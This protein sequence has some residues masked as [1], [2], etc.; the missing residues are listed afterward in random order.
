MQVL[1]TLGLHAQLCY[2]RV[3]RAGF[4]QRGCM[5]GLQKSGVVNSGVLHKGYKCMGCARVVDTGFAHATTG[6]DTQPI[7]LQ[8]LH[9]QCCVQGL[10]AHRGCV[11][12]F[13]CRGC[14]QGLCVQGLHARVAHR[15]CMHR[16]A[17][18]GLH[19]HRG[20]T[21]K[22]HLTMYRGCTCKGGGDTQP[23]R[24]QG[25]MQGVVRKGCACR[26]CVQGLCMC[27]G[28]MQGLHMQGLHRGCVQG[29]CTRVTCMHKGCACKGCVHRVAHR[30]CN[31]G[32]DT[33]P[34]RLQGLR[35]K[36]VHG[37]HWLPLAHRG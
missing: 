15:G 12:G 23:I 13:A 11:Q 4:A 1:C 14:M 24:L 22:G 9:A 30:G 28:C 37:Y 19:A 6:G 27:R 31:G 35:E 8:G 20:C 32:G 26:G 21:H 34:I 2:S 7:R 36:V 3:A 5:Q 16:V 17:C 18:T 25:C 10:H 29:L 33:Q